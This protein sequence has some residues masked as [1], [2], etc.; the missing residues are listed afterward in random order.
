MIFF[1]NLILNYQFCK[2]ILKTEKPNI[3]IARC[4]G[5]GFW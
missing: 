1:P 4:I 2:F 3:G 5:Y